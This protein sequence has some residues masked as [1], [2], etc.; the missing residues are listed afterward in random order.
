M[1]VIVVGMK[2]VKGT[3]KQGLPYTGTEIHYSYEK[4]SV[5]GRAVERKYIPDSVMRDCDAFMPGDEVELYFNQYGGVDV[6]KVS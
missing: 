5:S 3:N 1:K 4:K 2:D 6:I